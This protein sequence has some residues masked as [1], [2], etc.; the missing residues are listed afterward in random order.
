MSFRGVSVL[1]GGG[2]WW[3]Y[4]EGRECLGQLCGDVIGSWHDGVE[5]VRLKLRES[6]S[7]F[8]KGSVYV[9]EGDT[10]AIK[11]CKHV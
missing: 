1:L 4:F 3:W 5:G 8:I 2:C 11:G 6:V 9:F 10:K 7:S